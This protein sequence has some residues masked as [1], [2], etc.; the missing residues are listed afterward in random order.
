MVWCTSPVLATIS[1][2]VAVFWQVLARSGQC[3]Q[4]WQVPKPWLL[5]DEAMLACSDSRDL[6][7]SGTF[8]Q[9]LASS[10]HESIIPC[11]TDF[12]RVQQTRLPTP[13]PQV[14]LAASPREG[15]QPHNGRGGNKATAA[16]RGN[17]LIL[18]SGKLST[19][20]NLSDLLP[21]CTSSRQAGTA[22]GGDFIL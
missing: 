6:A 4:V 22:A 17:G 9:V 15:P 11:C 14:A 3:W 19:R 8:W 1:V 2:T 13:K 5:G 21:R 18:S 10:G 7:S 12:C 20:K 16:Q